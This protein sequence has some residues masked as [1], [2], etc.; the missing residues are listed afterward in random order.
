MHDTFS[1]LYLSNK[2]SGGASQLCNVV[3]SPYL[4]S[5]LSTD[6]KTQDESNMENARQEFASFDLSKY[7]MSLRIEERKQREA[8]MLDY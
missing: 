4:L 8:N 3:S 5:F 6:L 1:C 2:T 7:F